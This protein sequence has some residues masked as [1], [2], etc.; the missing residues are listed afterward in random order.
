MANTLTA[1]DPVF[2]E[3]MKQ[4]PRELVGMIPVAQR[5]AA[6]DRVALDD[7]SQ[8]PYVKVPI[9]TSGAAADYTAAMT[10]TAGGDTTPTT[11][12]IAIDNSRQV[13]WHLNGEQERNLLN[14]GT[15]LDFT[16]QKIQEGVRVLCNE[17]EAALVTAC[18]QSASRAYG[19]AGTTPFATTLLDLT[20][21]LQI[22]DENGAPSYPGARSVVLSPAAKAKLLALGSYSKANEAGT[23]RPLRTGAFADLFGCDVGASGQCTLHTS[24]VAAN[25]DTDLGATLAAG[26][27]TIHLDTG[28]GAVLAG[29]LA[30]FAGDANKYLVNT[31]ATGDGDKDIVIGAPGLKATL[32][33]GVDMTD[34]ADYTPNFVMANGAV[35]LAFRN[36]DIPENANIQ[37]IPYVDEKSGLAFLLCRIAG[38]GMVTYRIH[39]AYGVKVIQPE[40]IAIM[41]G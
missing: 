24:G 16:R 12:D 3:A 7:A 8:T 35:V 6:A 36:P 4:V 37:Q 22:L 28:T 30:I 38:D 2:Y 20:A 26:S 19:T 13:N 9:V 33:D 32:A 21:T 34:P 39:C 40:F 14:G 41:L 1:I 18:K 29:D 11:V 27:T 15:M 17:V 10:T 23:D 5:N 31:G 25:Y